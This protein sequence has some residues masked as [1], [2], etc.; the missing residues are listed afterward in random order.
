MA[1]AVVIVVVAHTTK[2]EP[3]SSG[4]KINYYNAHEVK[5]LNEYLTKGFTVN[6]VEQSTS[7]THTILTFILNKSH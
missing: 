1:Q 4:A 3:S 6:R 2:S 7:P 5:E